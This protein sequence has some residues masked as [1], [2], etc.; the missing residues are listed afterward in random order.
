MT[1]PSIL[2]ALFSLIGCFVAAGMNAPDAAAAAYAFPVGV[3]VLLT[4]SAALTSKICFRSRPPLRQIGWIFVHIAVF[5]AAFA[6]E[7][8]GW[9]M[10]RQR[11]IAPETAWF[12]PMVLHVFEFTVSPVLK[13]IQGTTGAGVLAVIFM[14]RKRAPEW[15]Y[16]RVIGWVWCGAM[17]LC[18]IALALA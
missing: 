16:A 15:V 4:G 12:G 7:E 18:V 13:V 6:M 9:A 3:A 1:R 8:F 11:A 14:I 2:I 17:S 10:W 5:A